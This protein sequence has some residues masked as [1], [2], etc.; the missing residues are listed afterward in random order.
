ME[1]M[2]FFPKRKAASIFSFLQ[3]VSESMFS[4]ITGIPGWS[5]GLEQ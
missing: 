5:E 3:S 2:T 1:G 4:V